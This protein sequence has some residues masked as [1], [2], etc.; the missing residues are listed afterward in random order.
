MTVSPRLTALHTLAAEHTPSGDKT[1]NGRD[2]LLLI[3]LLVCTCLYFSKPESKVL[4]QLTTSNEL[5]HRATLVKLSIY[6]LMGTLPL[7]L[8]AY[9]IGQKVLHFLGILPFD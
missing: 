3:Q 8:S 7:C 1:V 9:L 6:P 5:P 2:S 4:A